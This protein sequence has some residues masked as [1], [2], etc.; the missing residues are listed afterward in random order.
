MYGGGNSSS[1]ATDPKDKSLGLIHTHE[2]NLFEGKLNT[3]LRELMKGLFYSPVLS[4]K[5]SKSLLI[6][7]LLW[8]WG[9]EILH[10]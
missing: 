3:C 8:P 6:P 4:S 2:L 9:D 10:H 5:E 7:L 1:V